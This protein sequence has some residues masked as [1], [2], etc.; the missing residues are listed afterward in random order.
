MTNLSLDI[1][2]KS[3]RTLTAKGVEYYYKNDRSTYDKILYPYIENSKYNS[4]SLDV[5]FREIA[6]KIRSR[7]YNPINNPKNSLKKS[8]E[9]R[10]IEGMDLM[11]SF[12]VMIS[13]DKRDICKSLYKTSRCLV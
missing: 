4:S 9:L 3:N 7:K 8:I 13:E 10:T 12:D 11:F 2:V 5:Q 1:G 6:H